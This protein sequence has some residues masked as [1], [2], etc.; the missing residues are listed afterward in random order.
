MYL[1]KRI[2]DFKVL[3][4]YERMTYVIFLY[5]SWPNLMCILVTPNFALEL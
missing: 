5:I 2:R 3:T 1:I 4:H